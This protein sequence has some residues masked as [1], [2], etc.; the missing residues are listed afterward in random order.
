MALEENTLKNIKLNIL[1]S[2][3][4]TRLLLFLF[5]SLRGV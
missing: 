5:V 1:Y 3:I 2:E 4:K